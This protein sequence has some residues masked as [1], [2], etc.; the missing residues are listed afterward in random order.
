MGSGPCP[1][2]RQQPVTDILF[3]YHHETER[4]GH[5]HPV[6]DLQVDLPQDHPGAPVRYFSTP[7][8]NLPQ[9]LAA[10]FCAWRWC[11]A[12]RVSHNN[13]R[14]TTSQGEVWVFSGQL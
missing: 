7:P 10:K 4:E 13:G 6:P 9:L 1:L 11:A 14:S 2:E 5:G 8:L 3:L 12:R